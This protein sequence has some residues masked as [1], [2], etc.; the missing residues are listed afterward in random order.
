MMTALHKN[1]FF[2]S[3]CCKVNVM[4]GAGG[5]PNDVSDDFEGGVGL[6]IW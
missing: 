5:K 4:G 6:L 1:E 2:I 3:I